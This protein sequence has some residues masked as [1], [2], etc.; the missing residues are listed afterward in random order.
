MDIKSNPEILKRIAE[1][2]L[3]IEARQAQFNIDSA[4]FQAD[5]DAFKVQLATDQTYLLELRSKGLIP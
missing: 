4:K 1:L 5:L 3:R 2:R